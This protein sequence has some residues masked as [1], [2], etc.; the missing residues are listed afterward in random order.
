MKYVSFDDLTVMYLV[1]QLWPEEEMHIAGYTIDYSH[2]IG[3][4][5]L[6]DILS[7]FRF[8]FEIESTFLNNFCFVPFFLRM[9]C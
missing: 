3:Y 2:I 9:N 7:P 1:G 4:R 5:Q 8:G 6:F